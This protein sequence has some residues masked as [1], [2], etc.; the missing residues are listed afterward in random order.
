MGCGEGWDVMWE[1]LWEGMVGVNGGGGG[2][3]E[4]VFGVGWR[5][6]LGGECGECGEGGEEDG[7]CC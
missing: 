2:L 6:G 3:E 7:G 1:G 4:E 5:R